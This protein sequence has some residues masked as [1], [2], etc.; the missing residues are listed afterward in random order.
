MKKSW[1]CHAEER[2]GRQRSRRGT[3]TVA[4]AASFQEKVPKKLHTNRTA[5]AERSF[6][7]AAAYRQDD[8]PLTLL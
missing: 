6:R 3:A 1:L 2:I 8:K 7:A 4:E 5:E